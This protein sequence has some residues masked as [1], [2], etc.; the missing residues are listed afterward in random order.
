MIYRKF[1]FRH[2]DRSKL[3]DETYYNSIVDK[4]IRNLV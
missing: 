2:I 3:I 1:D 4:A